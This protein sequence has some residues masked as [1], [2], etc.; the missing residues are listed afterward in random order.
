M[1]PTIDKTIRYTFVCSSCGEIWSDWVS[2][3]LCPRCRE[4][5][6]AFHD[7]RYINPQKKGVRN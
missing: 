1:I 5:T 3:S 2:I 7:G 4:I 6:S